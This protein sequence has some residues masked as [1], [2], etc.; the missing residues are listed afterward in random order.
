[1]QI[2]LQETPSCTFYTWMQFVPKRKLLHLHDR[3]KIDL[4]GGIQMKTPLQLLLTGLLATTVAGYF[5]QN[6]TA[7]GSTQQPDGALFDRSMQFYAKKKYEQAIITLQTL[8]NS[9]PDSQYVDR[10]K[11]SLEDCW[12]LPDCAV[13]RIQVEPQLSN[14]GEVVTVPTL[15]EAGTLEFLCD[16]VQ[17]AEIKLHNTLPINRSGKSRSVHQSLPIILHIPRYTILREGTKN[18]MDAT[19]TACDPDRTCDRDLKARVQFKHFNS[20]GASGSY[21]IERSDGRK[22]AGT[23]EVRGKPA[24]LCE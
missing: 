24:S 3:R 10:A 4:S 6:K 1:M 13:A 16:K 20:N 14:G 19:A 2:E 22:Q 15:P 9:Y 23:F 8:I 5:Q 21:V 18:P 7:S 12:R 17:T 11:L